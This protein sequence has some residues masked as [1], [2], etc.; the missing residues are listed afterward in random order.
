MIDYVSFE[1][2]TFGIIAVSLHV[3]TVN[4][5]VFHAIGVCLHPD[6]NTLT[7]R[8]CIKSSDKKVTFP[9]SPKVPT[10]LWF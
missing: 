3:G 1:Y 5:F 4:I 8:H 10:C 2:N 6:F 9:T 7:F